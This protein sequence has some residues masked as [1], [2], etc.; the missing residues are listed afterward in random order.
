M[1]WTGSSGEDWECLA[2]AVIALVA[3]LLVLRFMR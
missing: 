1:K 3:M 2:M